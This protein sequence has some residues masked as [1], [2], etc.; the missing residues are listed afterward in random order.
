[1]VRELLRDP[2]LGA[3]TSK[4]RNAE[5]EQL[6]DFEE[7]HVERSSGPERMAARRHGATAESA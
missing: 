6:T 7:L 5:G 1:M 3:I 4:T 2:L